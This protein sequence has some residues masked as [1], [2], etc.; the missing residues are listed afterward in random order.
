MRSSVN[1]LYNITNGFLH[2]MSQKSLLSRG[3]RCWALNYD[4][5]LD[6]NTKSLSF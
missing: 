2:G 6:K 1:Y 4:Y 5:D 3:D